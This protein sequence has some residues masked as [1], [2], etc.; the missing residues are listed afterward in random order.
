[1]GVSLATVY[2]VLA[3]CGRNRPRTLVR[4]KL[5]RYEKGRPGELLHMDLK[6]LQDLDNRTQEYHYAAI[7]DC[8]RQAVA[9]I[10][11]R[12]TSR[13]AV[14]FL[15]R[16][17]AIKH[18][19]LRP[20]APESNTKSNDSSKQSTTNTSPVADHIFPRSACGSRR[21]FCG[22]TTFSG[23]TSAWAASLR[24]NGVKPTSSRLRSDLYLVRRNQNPRISGA[25]YP[26]ENLENVRNLFQSFKSFAETGRV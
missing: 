22:T 12:R 7:N 25:R 6:Y 19:L 1:M 17:L 4:R 3:R 5:L 18:R 26:C 13:I 23:P 8:T 24:S 16:A 11:S 2:R 10:G 15:G 14:E 21:C 20:H 9:S